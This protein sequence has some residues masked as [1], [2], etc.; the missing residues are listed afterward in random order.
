MDNNGLRGRSM[1]TKERFIMRGLE[2]LPIINLRDVQGS[3]VIAPPTIRTK[4]RKCCCGHLPTRHLFCTCCEKDITLLCHSWN[5]RQRRH[6]TMRATPVA[7]FLYFVLASSRALP[8]PGALPSF[9][10][11]KHHRVWVLHE[12]C[13]HNSC[14]PERVK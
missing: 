5:C 11:L 2:P 4:K 12:L 7:S 8:F 13:G 6:V 14:P 1:I 3:I 10:K 9:A